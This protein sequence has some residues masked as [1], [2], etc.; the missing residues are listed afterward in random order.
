MHDIHL[1]ICRPG[2]RLAS[3]GDDKI[4][5]IWDPADGR[6][7][8]S[9]EGMIETVTEVAFTSD[10]NTLLA[11]GTDKAVRV[12]NLETS[13]VRHTL[14]GHSGK[15]GFSAQGIFARSSPALWL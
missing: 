3:G 15:V 12:F 5:R 11:A 4:I 7:I 8:G 14:T 10:S 1:P 2:A 13:R 6:P 9:L